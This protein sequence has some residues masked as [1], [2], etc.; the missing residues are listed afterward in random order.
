VSHPFHSQVEVPQVTASY[1][2]CNVR[3][4]LRSVQNPDAVRQLNSRRGGPAA[5]DW[6]PSQ[7]QTFN[8]R[9]GSLH[10]KKHSRT[11]KK[12]F[13]WR[14]VWNTKRGGVEDEGTMATLLD[15]I[16]ECWTNQNLRVALLLRVTGF[17]SRYDH[18]LSWM[19]G[20]YSAPK[21]VTFHKFSNSLLSN[22]PITWRYEVKSYWK[23]LLNTP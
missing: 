18:L 10:N 7:T 6:S 1:G 20:L 23:S 17:R 4:T 15:T 13:F 5:V 22:F 2:S 14:N 11:I 16:I 8:E 9:H 3:L 12:N 21:S 19:C